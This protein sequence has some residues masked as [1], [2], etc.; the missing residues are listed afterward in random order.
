MFV[1]VFISFALIC[2]VHVSSNVIGLDFGSDSMK[3]GI[4]QPGQA[5]GTYA[6]IFLCCCE[7]IFVG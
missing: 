1:Q 6:S 5:L 3:I 2:I 7:S 4:V